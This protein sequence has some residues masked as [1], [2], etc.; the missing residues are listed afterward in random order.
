MSL[1]RVLHFMLYSFCLASPANAE[2]TPIRWQ[3]ASALTPLEQLGLQIF[4]DSNLSSPAGQSCASCHDPKV[5]F[6]DSTNTA[7]VSSG[8]VAGRQGSRNTP[9]IAYAL[10]SPT[11]SWDKT[12]NTYSGGQFLDGRAATAN[13]QAKG[14]FLNPLEMNNASAAAVVAKLRN[15]EYAGLFTTVFGANALAD[16][17]TAFD[18]MADALVAFEKTALFSRFSSKYDY[19]LA[20]KV[21]LTALEKHGME[22]FNDENKG[23]CAACHPSTAN[24]STPPLFTDFTYDNLG[25]PANTSMFA[26][27]SPAFIDLGLGVTVADQAQN[28][29]FKVPTLRNIAKTAPYMHNGVFQTLEEVIDFYNTRDVNRQWAPA[30]VSANKNVDELGNLNLSAQQTAALAAFLRTLSDGYVQQLPGYSALTQILEL[31]RVQIDN[32]P[33]AN[34]VISAK[35]QNV[36]RGDKVYFRVLSW[37]NTAES[38]LPEDS[39]ALPYYSTVTQC[40]EIPM[41]R[42]YNQGDYIVQLK[43]VM[44]AEGLLFELVYS[45]PLA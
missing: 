19:Y 4:Y 20:G 13:A 27:N 22:V 30:E 45:K 33:Y 37:Q 23:N 1:F 43:R 7:A 15:A 26:L 17:D 10:F 11:F 28:G 18:L 40:L 25:V 16:N 2:V 5:A 29:K 35:L 14:P 12:T 21:Q 24:G 38:I 8:A 6:S 39:A 34:A 9:S 44:A 42:V 36:S 32:P 31:P 41:L 3:E